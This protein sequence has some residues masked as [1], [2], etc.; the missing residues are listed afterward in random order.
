MILYS[1]YAI[2]RAIPDKL[3]GVIAMLS[4]ILVW[5]LLPFYKAV[6]MGTNGP[7]SRLHHFFFWVFS[8]VFLMLLILGG[9]PATQPY[10][11]ASQIFSVAYF[12]YFL[13][14]LFIL[15]FFE[16]YLLK[17]FN[18]PSSQRKI[19]PI[20]SSYSHF[21]IKKKRKNLGKYTKQTYR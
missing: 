15:P 13:I 14:V 6:D 19:K 12:A 16:N 9:A 11:K 1:I 3:G 21:L 2:L 18:F 20:R 5:A 17:Y 4:A 10:V 8:F 7:R